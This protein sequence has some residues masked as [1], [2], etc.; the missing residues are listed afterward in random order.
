M[1]ILSVISNCNYTRQYIYARGT[2][3]ILNMEASNDKWL[4]LRIKK[5]LL[6][7]SDDLNSIEQPKLNVTVDAFYFM[8][9]LRPTTF[10]YY[11]H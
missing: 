7:T 3:S 5:K 8:R 9:I 11:V 2:E 10:T 4:Q 1:Q 6:S